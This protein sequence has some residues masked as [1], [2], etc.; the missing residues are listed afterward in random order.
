MTKVAVVG[1]GSMGSAILQGLA[2]TDQVE[3]VAA[4]HPNPRAQQLAD[5]LG[6]KLYEEN[7][8]IVP[9]QPDVVILTVPVPVTLAVA[10]ELTDL[11][12]G[13]IVMSAAVGVSSGDLQAALPHA[14]IV[15]FVPNTP[16]AINAG[17]IGVA[18]SEQ[19]TADQRQ[20]AEQ[21]LGLLG[22]V[23][24]VPEDQMDIVGTVGGCGPA[25]VD[26]MMDAMSDAAVAKGLDRATAYQ[27][28]AS[29]VKGTG[30]LA[31]ESDLTPGQLRDQVTSPA[32][33]TIRGVMALEANGF[34][35]AVIEAINKSAE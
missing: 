34:R 22:D 13:T 30:A 8:E 31:S 27:L 1:T 35:H 18:F 10:K 24:P 23:I 12:S 28:I 17:T 20:L 7:S 33:T 29:M 3:L 6:F 14:G 9:E 25:F 4:N 32:G 15:P 11:A 26:V 19:L 2:K 5:Q 16:V 21:V